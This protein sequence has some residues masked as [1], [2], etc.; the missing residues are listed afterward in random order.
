MVIKSPA[1]C[2]LSVARTSVMWDSVTVRFERW[3]ARL[4]NT[5]STYGCHFSAKNVM[6]SVWEQFVHVV[7]ETGDVVSVVEH[8]IC[9]ATVDTQVGYH[10]CQFDQSP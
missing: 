6:R 1:N 3:D 9:G 5:V 7:G 4:V 8:D 10:V 2:D